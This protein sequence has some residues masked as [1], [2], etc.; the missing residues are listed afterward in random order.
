[1]SLSKTFNSCYAARN[2]S[3]MHS[4]ELISRTSTLSAGLPSLAVGASSS[5]SKIA[6]HVE[7]L[8]A[9]ARLHVCRLRKYVS[10][11]TLYWEC[12]K[13]SCPCAEDERKQQHYCSTC[14][15]L[16]VARCVF[17]ERHRHYTARYTSTKSH[18]LMQESSGTGRTYFESFRLPRPEARLSCPSH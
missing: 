8:P 9:D 16:R 10:S 11:R 12:Y 14:S 18:C 7:R 3:M 4:I 13:H 15:T 6:A 5:L 2:R 17:L 1:L